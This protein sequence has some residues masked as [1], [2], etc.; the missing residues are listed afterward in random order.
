MEEELDVHNGPRHECSSTL[1]STHPLQFQLSNRTSNSP[2][3]PPTPRREKEAFSP[4]HTC[5]CRRIPPTQTPWKNSLNSLKPEARSQ[6][7]D[8]DSGSCRG[9]SPWQTSLPRPC[10]PNTTEAGASVCTRAHLRQSLRR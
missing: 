8:R 2:L 9:V 6:I 1:I 5:V 10:D 7:H 3:H 4:T